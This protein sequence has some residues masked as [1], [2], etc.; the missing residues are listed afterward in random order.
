V[1]AVLFIPLSDDNP[2]RF[3][4]YQWVTIGIIVVNV[5]VYALQF[6]G[7]LL[8]VGTSLSVVPAEL[9]QARGPYG[10]GRG[11]FDGLPVPEWLTLVTYMFLHTDVLHLASNM[12]FLWVFGDNVEDAMGHLRYLAF[13]LLCGV[14]AGLAQALILPASQLPLVGASGA[15]AGTIAA[16][17]ILHPR[18]LVWVLAFRVLPLRI[19]A[20]WILGVWLLTQLFM[21]LINRGEYVAWWA[22]IGGL[23][24]G[25]LLVP[26]LK[27]ADVPLFDRGVSPVDTSR[28][29]WWREY[30][31]AILHRG[32]MRLRNPLRWLA[33]L[34]R[35]FR[36]AINRY[37][38][39]AKS[40]AE[41]ALASDRQKRPAQ[42]LTVETA[43][44]RTA[45]ILSFEPRGEDFA[46]VRA[47]ADGSRAEIVLTPTNL[48]HLGLL[49]PG[50]ARQVLTD[51]AGRQPGA[52]ASVVR[53]ATMRTNLR[54]IEL[55]LT[56]L[57]KGGERL[58]FATTERRARAL[59][60]RLVEHADKI[61][62][63][64]RSVREAR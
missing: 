34:A 44:P 38:R 27:R 13:Y 12:M 52:I 28:D 30:R 53:H 63:V 37:A 62:N 61:A 25:A 32:L 64:P 57:D 17:L 54:M 15:V 1:T 7:L 14:A 20:A 43:A 18:V 19:T 55:L 47:C 21:V 42:S 41:Q 6:S 40:W 16:Y 59:A 23:L 10:Y 8:A 31:A 48:V 39:I 46:L 9:L 58:D 24:T 4:R 22:H 2:L 60:S 45:D 11:A 49:A 56:I 33:S 35:Y 5:V 36:A 3:V 51:T 29:V 26:L 50:F